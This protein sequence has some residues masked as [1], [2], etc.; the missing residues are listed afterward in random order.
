MAKFIIVYTTLPKR[1]KARQLSKVLL[2]ERLIACANIFKIDSI[3]RWKGEV[4]ETGEYGVFFKTKE[5]LWTDLESRIKELHPYEVPAVVSFPIEKGSKD[6]LNWIS[7]E[8]RKKK[9]PI[10]VV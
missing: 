4:Q 2:K 5:E 7:E 9:P 10:R 8:T 3:Y 6:F 1:R